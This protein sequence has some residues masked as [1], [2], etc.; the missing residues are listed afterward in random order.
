MR[1]PPLSGVGL[2]GTA[3]PAGLVYTFGGVL[4]VD[5]DEENVSGNCTNDMH[6][7]DLAKQVWRLVE[8]REPKKSKAATSSKDDAEMAD[9]SA[10]ATTE[11]AAKTVSSDGVFTMVLGGGASASGTSD[12]LGKKST[13]AAVVSTVPSARMKAA[14]VVCKKHLYLYGGTV[15]DGN[16]QCTLADLYSLGEFCFF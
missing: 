2:T 6:S 11:A 13:T 15:E 16:K 4:D 5:E 8:L 10:S 3:T 14:L 7:F 1:P 12:K 9:E